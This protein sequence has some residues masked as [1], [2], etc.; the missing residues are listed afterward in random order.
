MADRQAVQQNLNGL[1]SKLDDPDP[2]MRYMSLNDLLGILNSPTSAYL[3][4]DQF[5]SSRLADGLLNALDDQ[6]GD[7][8]NQALKCLG[9][10]VNRLPSESLTTILEKLSNLTASQTIDTSVPNTALRVIVTALPR[11]QAGQPPTPDVSMAYSSVSKILIPRLTGPTPS[12]SGRRGS[13]IKGMLEKDTSKGFSSDAIDVLI[14][15]VTCFGPLLKEAELTALQK[16]VIYTTGAGKGKQCYCG[17]T[18]AHCR[19]PDCQIDYGHCDAHMTPDGPPTSGI[20]RPKI[21]KVQYGPK[22]VR[23]CVGAGNVALTFDDGPNKYTEDLLDLLDK[24]D[25]KVTFFITGN[26]NAKGPIDTPGMPWAS[27]IERMYQSGHQIASHTWSHQDLSKITPEQRRIQILWNEVALRNILGG[28]PTYMRPPYSSCTEESGCLKDIGNLGYHVILYDID[29]E[30]YRHDSPN[31]IQGS[32]DIF[33]KN[34]ARGKASDK[35]WLVIAHDVH[36]QTVYNLTEHMLK[37]ASKDG[38][39]VVTVGECLGDPEENWYRMDESSELTILRKTKPL[40]T[41]KHA[42]SRDGRCGGNVTC[43][44]SKFGTCCGKNGYCGTSP[45]HCGFGC[46]PNAGHCQK[47]RHTSTVHRHGPEKRPASSDA[48]SLLQPGL[49]VADLLLIAAI[50]GLVGVPW[51][52]VLVLL[53]RW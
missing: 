16:S 27:M 10:L 3:A 45:K 35:S 7:V 46:Q 31:A 18:K 6:H 37:K 12:Q 25:A 33:D 8:Q 11:S 42:I 30:D 49:N 19:S 39:N 47:A 1:L 4:H 36:K 9:P 32:K 15:V 28:F 13:V 53:S 34:L 29:T 52:L 21:G 43:L 51:P 44:G 17:K 40:A 41:A 48:S 24:Y 23:S 20:P 50:A 2:D 38:Y 5:S 26:N 22:A 14:Q